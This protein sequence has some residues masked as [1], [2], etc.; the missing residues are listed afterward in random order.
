MEIEKEKERIIKFLREKLNEERKD[1]YVLGVSG[2]IDSAV[3]S[4]LLKD[5]V[6]RERIFALIMP[7]MDSEPASVEDALLVVENLGIPYKVFSLTKALWILG[8]YKSVPLFFFLFRPLKRRVVKYL[9][10]EYSKILGKPVFFAQ[11]EKLNIK[12]H[13]F[14]EGIAYHRIK[15][16]LRMALLYF[17]AER[18]NYLVVGCNNLTESLIG[19]YVR[20]GD[21]ASDI[22][23]ISHLYK[24]EIR[25]L[26]KILG[27]PRR[28]IEKPPSP[29]LLPGISDEFSLGLDYITLD[30]I[31][32]SFEEGK[33]PSQLKDFDEKLI[34]LVYDQYLWVK[35]ESKKPLRLVREE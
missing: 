4:Y 17:F 20:Y 2:G 23:P 35:R 24:T 5:A 33:E 11:K 22:E 26:A 27:I 10:S 25:E 31:L 19:Y 7:E 30:R 8:V 9:Y 12:L 21:D 3:V 34:K 15:H 28:I 14:Y 6:G 1:G 16:R 29:D 18:K 13:W 32:K